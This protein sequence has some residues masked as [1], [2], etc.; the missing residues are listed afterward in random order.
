MK[1]S[2]YYKK[3]MFNL[4]KETCLHVKLNNTNLP[5][6]NTLKY[7]GIHF[8]IQLTAETKAIKIKTPLFKTRVVLV[9]RKCS[10]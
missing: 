3:I 2:A 5:Q 7:L 4:H 6:L 9:A 10:Q 8:D 1:L